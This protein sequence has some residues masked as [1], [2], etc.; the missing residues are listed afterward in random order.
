VSFRRRRELGFLASSRGS[1]HAFADFYEAISPSVLRFFANQ[2]R[3]P[4]AAFDLT[5]ETFAKAFEK[6]RDFRGASNEQAAAWVWA[7][8]R[9]ELA[10]FRRSRS[11][12]FAAL[13]RL[14]LERPD[15]SDTELQEVERLTTSEE[16]RLHLRRAL[17][18]LPA[19]QREVVRLRFLEFL[20][21][22]EIAARLGVSTDVARARTSRALKTLR[23]SEDVHKAVHALRG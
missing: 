5:A 19:D 21:Y 23:S 1:P 22:E 9:S 2:T 7:I 20:G 6:R 12:E 14:K 10:R 15:P 16:A 3:Y 18:A 8:A 13:T 11:V 17:G 4:Q